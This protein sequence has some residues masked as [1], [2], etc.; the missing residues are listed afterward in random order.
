MNLKTKHGKYNYKRESKIINLSH[1][2][3][4]GSEA[5]GNMG[6]SSLVGVNIV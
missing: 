4:Q 6:E 5:K 1:A 3:N 2:W